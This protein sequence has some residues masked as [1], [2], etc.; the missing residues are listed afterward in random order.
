MSKTC[1]MVSVT[2]QGLYPQ[3]FLSKTFYHFQCITVSTQTIYYT[4]QIR[5]NIYM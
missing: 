1:Y 4:K 3:F 5:S 2:N